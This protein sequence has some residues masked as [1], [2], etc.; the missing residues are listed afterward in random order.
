M[1]RIN[2]LTNLATVLEVMECGGTLKGK[3]F[4]I[5]G[6]LA[7]PRKDII[8]IIEQAGGRFEEQPRWGVNYL[9]TNKD[10]NAGS[11]I[12]P[13]KSSKMIKAEQNGI[14]LISESQFYDMIMKADAARPEGAL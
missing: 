5:T 6:H 3:V 4:S 10:F 1:A 12:K 8:S 7:R 9:I 2:E 13:N 14:K 11:T